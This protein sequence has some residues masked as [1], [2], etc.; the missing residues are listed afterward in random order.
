M[1]SKN[2]RVLVVDDTVV[3]RKIVSDLLSDTDGIDVVGTATNGKNALIKIERLQPDL[4]TLDLEM[5][6]MDGLEVLSHLKAQ[7][8]PV[9]AIMLS[10]VTTQGADATMKA[11]ALGAFD[12]VAKPSG[13]SF[14]ENTEVLRQDLC[15]KIFAYAQTRS[16]LSHH[17]GASTIKVPP[18][19]DIPPP[20]TPVQ[21]PTSGV[22][23]EVVVLGIS[24]GGPQAL[25]QM[26][27]KLPEDLPVPMLIVQHMPS[28]FTKSLGGQPG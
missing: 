12:F 6:E 8:S 10:A 21:R 11:L 22:K 25:T 14:E 1:I 18:Q 19:T 16:S 2:V 26:L 15:P 28:K 4:L 7:N 13:D 24:T 9:G 3:Y 20:L 17:A 5:P 23:P 27:P